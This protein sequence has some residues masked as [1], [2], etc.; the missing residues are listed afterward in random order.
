MY[1]HVDWVGQGVTSGRFLTQWMDLGFITRKFL[2]WLSVLLAIQ[3]GR[4]IE[5]VPY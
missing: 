4:F 2:E 3:K 5:L 1:R